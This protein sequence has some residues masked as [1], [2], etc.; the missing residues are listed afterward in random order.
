MK[1]CLNIYNKRLPTDFEMLL[2][3]IRK[4]RKL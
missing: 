1:E 4:L 3:N 2:D